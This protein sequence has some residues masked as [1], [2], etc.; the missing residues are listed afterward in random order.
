MPQTQSTPIIFLASANDRADGIGYLRNLPDEMRRIRTALEPVER[1]GL[2]ELITRQ[3]ATLEDILAVF[4]Q[5]E[6]RNRIAIFHY[7]GHANGYQL[8]LEDREGGGALADAGGLADFLAQQRGLE[9]V[10]LNGCS[11]QPQVQGL[12]GAGIGAVVAT[13]Q[14]IDDTVA[15]RFAESFYQSLAGSA[16]LEQAYHEAVATQHT[17]HGNNTRAAYLT[18]VNGVPVDNLPEHS[19]WPW[20]LYTRDGAEI[21]GQWSLPKAANDPLFGLPALPLTD[22]PQSPFRHLSWFRRED[23]A[24]FFGRGHQIRELYSRI[25]NATGAPIILFYGQSGVGKSS[26]LAAGLL[27]RL[28]ATHTVRYQRRHREQG[29]LGALAEAMGVRNKQPTAEQL[30][31]AWLG[32]EAEDKQPVVLL[33]DQVEEIFTRPNAANPEELTSFVLLLKKMFS[34]RQARPQGKLVLSFRKEWLAEIEKLFTEAKL[35]RSSLFLTRL[36]RTGVIEAIEGAARDQ[37]LVDRYG[38]TIEAGLAAEIA[39]DLLVDRGATVAPTLQI[40]LTKLWEEARQ[41]SYEAPTFDQ[42]LYHELR[43]HGLLLEDFLDEQ[44]AVL[45]GDDEDAL[46]TGLT[47]DLLA[48]HTTAVGTAEQRSLSEVRETYRHQ[49][50][51]LENLLRVC[52]DLYLLTDS[53]TNQP[54]VE[55]V[56]RLAHDTLAPLVRVRFDESDAPGQR[57]RRILESRGVDWQEGQDGAALDEIDLATVEAGLAGMRGLTADEE[58][59]IAASRTERKR[60]EAERQRIAA[61]QLAAQQRELFLQRQS[62]RRLQMVVGILAVVSLGLLGNTLY[63][64]Y[65]AWRMQTPLVSILAGDA[66]LGVDEPLTDDD[67]PKGNYN[68]SAFHIEKYEVSNRQ[69]ARCV[70]VGRCPPMSDPTDLNNEASAKRPV[71]NVN[72]FQAAVYCQW[73]GR[74]LPTEFEWERAARGTSG[75]LWPWGRKPPSQELTQMPSILAESMPTV[76]LPVD[77][78]GKG[79]SDDGVHHLVGNLWEWTLPAR[80]NNNNEMNEIWQTLLSDPQSVPVLT[81]RGGSYQ[82]SITNITDRLPYPPTKPFATFGFRCAAL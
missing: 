69:Y 3:N 64:R 61:E 9:F 43:T 25:T 38:L 37:R 76:T 50:G 33:L 17:M 22:L 24:L 52:Q 67:L 35:P 54:G 42:D 15:T 40:L 1:A 53:S 13:A 47:L 4:Q 16:T 81:L 62:N 75:N 12:L 41:R 5:A 65:V 74:R 51:L 29:V 19:R 10:F 56:S 26:L 27:P 30:S 49:W 70:Q 73:V 68:L 79:A 59:L 36:D 57:A 66:I 72:A 82:D 21:T 63:P 44:L 23:A 60:K 7:A 71:R 31:D 80:I 6:H 2:C 34:E 78:L 18:T 48:F 20:M 58:R 39:D 14:A 28:E 45:Q 77:S 55:P 32:L 46:L 8:L 11:T